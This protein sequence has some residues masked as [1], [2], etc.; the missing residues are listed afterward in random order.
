MHKPSGGHINI[1]IIKKENYLICTID[2]NGIGRKAAV[3]IERDNTLKSKSHGLIVTGKRLSIYND[4]E[5]D[6]I[7]V[8]DKNDENGKASGTTVIIKILI[9]RPS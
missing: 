4:S 6:Q 3:E 2:D 7:T 1:S 8:I 5:K 9:K